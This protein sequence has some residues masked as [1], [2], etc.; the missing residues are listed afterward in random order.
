MEFLIKISV[1]S[2]Y[3][4]CLSKNSGA[5]KQCKVPN[6]DAGSCIQITKCQPLN[7][8]YLKKP[9]TEK[10]HLFIQQSICSKDS[11]KLKVCCPSESI[12]SSFKPNPVIF[13][14]SPVSSANKVT[15]KPTIKPIVGGAL[16]L[17]L[18]TGIDYGP[19][20]KDYQGNCG[21]DSSNAN[22]ISGGGPTNIDE[23][24]WLALLEYAG[25]ALACGGSLISSKFVLTAAH[26]LAGSSG[27]PVK[28]RLAEYNITSYPTDYV[29]I[30]GGGTDSI[31]VTIIPVKSVIKH[32]GFNRALRIN[33][34][35]IVEM[36]HSATFSDF[37]KTICLPP[38]NYMSEFSRNTN[39][40]VAGWGNDNSIRNE[41][42]LQV[43]VP[44]MPTDQ[45]TK[46]Q[47]N[48]ILDTQICAGG[49]KGKDS[50]SGD[51]GGPLMYEKDQIYY[52]VGV[53]SYGRELCGTEGVPAVY[54]NVYKYVDWIRDVMDG[55]ITN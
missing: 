23:Y 28:V 6:G 26:C 52:A 18:A 54:T 30:D 19:R 1:V 21:V 22:K 55:T 50:C 43:T 44:F 9:K 29:E 34:I 39:F 33:D 42:K 20:I 49:I 15:R 8:L 45:C 36:T 27:R 24:P 35:G 11:P 37:I 46:V 17:T 48:E 25:G 31:N 7:D 40:T 4:L 13:P 14:D 12:W 38:A 51:S 41:V 2:L 47:G 3:V 5:Y 10:E 53:V 16:P 32:P